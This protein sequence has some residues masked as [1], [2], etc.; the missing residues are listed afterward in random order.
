MHGELDFN[1]ADPVCAYVPGSLIPGPT[2]AVA[3]PD[4]TNTCTGSAPG[5]LGAA[6]TA[7]RPSRVAEPEQQRPRAEVLDSTGRV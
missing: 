6:P 2:Q 7:A 5:L 4:L 3:S 1:T